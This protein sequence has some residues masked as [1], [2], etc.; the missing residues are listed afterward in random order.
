MNFL[1]H[2]YFDRKENDPYFNF[3]LLFPDLLRNFIKGAKLKPKFDQTWDQKELISLD[4][5][6]TKH[7]Y[8]DKIFHGWDGF[9]DGMQVVIDEIRNSNIEFRKDWFIAHILVELVLDKILINRHPNLAT[10]LYDDYEQVEMALVKKF[11]THYEIE[12]AEEF[13]KGFDHFMQVRYLESYREYTNIVYALGRIYT[14]MKLPP[15]SKEQKELL[16]VVAATTEK[17]MDNRIE[18]LE[19]LL[20]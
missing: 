5:G 16:L 3:G 13:S 1:S 20:K 10:Q 6:C 12:G 17:A 7:V 11:I 2:F 8:S 18:E 15:F 9:E 4:Q 14:K 19:S